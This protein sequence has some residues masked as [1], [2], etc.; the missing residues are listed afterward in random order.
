M[1]SEC[2][3]HLQI[4]AVLVINHLQWKTIL[5]I[6]LQS[7]Q[8]CAHAAVFEHVSVAFSTSDLQIPYN[9]NSTNLYP[10]PDD[11]GFQQLDSKGNQ[12]LGIDFY[13]TPWPLLSSS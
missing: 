13:P 11:T 5:L 10:P 9:Q 8:T 7:Y 6:L 3:L 12:S 1:V 4:C 2:L